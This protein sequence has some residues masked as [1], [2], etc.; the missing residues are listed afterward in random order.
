M[1][2]ADDGDLKRLVT[3]LVQHTLAQL[4][5]QQVDVE[6][7]R[8]QHQLARRALRI[9][10][11]I[12]DGGQQTAR[13]HLEPVN[14]FLLPFG[15][16]GAPQQFQQVQLRV[17]WRTHF[18]AHISQQLAF[19]T[20]GGIGPFACALQLEFASLALGNVF[21]RAHAVDQFVLG[22]A[23]WSPGNAKAPWL[24]ADHDF[25]ILDIAFFAVHGPKQ[26]VQA[27]RKTLGCAGHLAT[28]RVKHIGRN[29]ARRLLVQRDQVYG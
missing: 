17:D 10:Q 23:H 19:G 5:H 8:N 18:A 3:N 4:C 28:N 13:H 12:V 20:A 15:Q 11:H 14:V 1:W 24:A 25:Q 26:G 7:A 9:V 22:I 2:I 16:L 6:Q 21:K 29:L 27:R